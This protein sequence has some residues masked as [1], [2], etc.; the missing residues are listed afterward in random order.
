MIIV[1]NALKAR[2]MEGRPIRV[3]LIGAGFMLTG[4]REPHREY[5]AGN[6]AGGR[7]Q[8]NATTRVRSMPVRRRAGSCCLR[9]QH[10]IGPR[11]SSRKSGRRPKM[12]CCWRAPPRVDVS[13]T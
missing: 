1:D 6:E 3:A 4:T 8:P 7:L 12:P 5:N 13:W 11:D 10:E 9:L 2:E